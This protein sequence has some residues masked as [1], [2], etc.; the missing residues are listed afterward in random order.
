M[1]KNKTKQI[2]AE[3][4]LL[5]IYWLFS[6]YL[7]L[8]YKALVPDE[9]WFLLDASI[10]R[11]LMR[12][13]PNLGYGSLYWGLLYFLKSPF[14]I[15]FSFWL[16]NILIPMLIMSCFE[17]EKIRLPVILLF[18]TFPFSFWS[19]KLI[20]PEIFVLFLLSLSMYF[21]F[22]SKI[23]YASFFWGWQLVSK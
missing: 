20:G 10:N 4:I 13:M 11:Y 15:R 3:I 14:I 12:E 16:M 22:H 7:F 8:S 6:A 23:K 19:G 17:D 1:N 5:I 2:N 9:K 18:L 21:I